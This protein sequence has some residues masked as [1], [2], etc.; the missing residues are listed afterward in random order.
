MILRSIITK[1][2][3]VRRR[4]VVIDDIADGAGLRCDHVSTKLN[5]HHEHQER[6]ESFDGWCGLLTCVYVIAHSGY[7][8]VYSEG[9]PPSDIADRL[10]ASFPN[11][12]SIGISQ[13]TTKI[14][15]ELDKYVSFVFNPIR[16]GDVKKQGRSGWSA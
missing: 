11:F 7:A 16:S 9:G 2:E 12:M 13:R 14:I 8:G 10:N 6:V 5:V 1:M 15:A 4:G 3:S